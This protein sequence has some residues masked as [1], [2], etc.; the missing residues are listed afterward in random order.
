MYENKIAGVMREYEGCITKHLAEARK[1]QK[2]SMIDSSLSVCAAA[3]MLDAAAIIGRGIDDVL[4]KLS[5]P[6]T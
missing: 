3:S 2:V 6:R 4:G 1:A 5:A